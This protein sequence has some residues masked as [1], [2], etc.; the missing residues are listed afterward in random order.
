MGAQFERAIEFSLANTIC[1]DTIGEAR[2]IFNNASLNTNGVRIVALDGTVIQ[3]NGNISGGFFAAKSGANRS[4]NMKDKAKKQK[5]RDL[6]LEKLRKIDDVL[7]DDSDCEGNEE[8][9]AANESLHDLQN[10]Q[11]NK[12]FRVQ[13]LKQTLEEKIS[14]L[15][16][17]Q[18]SLRDLGKKLK[19]K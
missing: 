6:L 12:E 5:N 8:N 16:A 10:R 9:E 14:S 18:K 7:M 19:K 1:V 15:K 11:K 4:L 13:T 2:D 3:P 17:V